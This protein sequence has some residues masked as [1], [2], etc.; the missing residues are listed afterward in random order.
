V[1][2]D[3]VLCTHGPAEISGQDLE[4][5][6]ERGIKVCEAKIARLEGEGGCLSFIVFTNGTRL[7]RRA[8]FFSTGQHPRSTLLEELGCRYGPKG[9]EYD[10]DGRT[11]IPGVFVAGDVSRD[12]QIAI[13][14]AAEGARAALAINRAL[15]QNSGT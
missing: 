11:S 14:A 1:T 10:D 12:V 3:L 4:N 9:I 8:L 2:S 15:G 13:I 6:G 5:L 7:A